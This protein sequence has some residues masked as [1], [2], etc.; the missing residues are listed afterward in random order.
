MEPCNLCLSVTAEFC[1]L[2]AMQVRCISCSMCTALQQIVLNHQRTLPD[3]WATGVS[4]HTSVQHVLFL[5]SLC[6]NISTCLDQSPEA[7]ALPPPL[8]FSFM[9]CVLLPCMSLQVPNAPSIHTLFQLLI[10]PCIH[11]YN[12]FI[13]RETCDLTPGSEEDNNNTPRADAG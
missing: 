1:S 9:L 4:I 6:S 11:P 13:Q 3:V 8:S 2:M 5:S 10:C 7:R 12:P